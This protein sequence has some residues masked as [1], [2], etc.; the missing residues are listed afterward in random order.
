MNIKIKTYQ[1]T[2]TY[3]YAYA[4]TYTYT[5][6][7]TVYGFIYI[8]TYT[9]KYTCTFTHTDTD[10]HIHIHIYIH[11]HTHTYIPIHTHTS[12]YISIHT[13][14][15]K[16]IHMNTYDKWLWN[17]TYIYMYDLCN[18]VVYTM[19]YKC[20]AKQS[21]AMQ[22][23]Y[24]Y[25]IHYTVYQCIWY[26]WYYIARIHGKLNDRSRVKLLCIWRWIVLTAWLRLGRGVPDEDQQVLVATRCYSLLLVAT[27][28]CLGHLGS[29]KTC[30]TAKY[31]QRVSFKR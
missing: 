16:W 12:P 7:Y 24:I 13:Y 5:Y 4:Y 26:I 19:Q 11:I 21:S 28:W 9:Y 15:Y 31:R 10:L 25:I 22:C 23:M 29:S 27:P 14:T 20:N 30:K 18:N 1:C 17:I 8:Y 3:T 6:T 2:R